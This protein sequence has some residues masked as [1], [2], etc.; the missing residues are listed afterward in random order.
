MFSIETCCCDHCDQTVKKF[1]VFLTSNYLKIFLIKFLEKI[2]LIFI[3]LTLIIIIQLIINN[4]TM[5][6]VKVI[7]NYFINGNHFNT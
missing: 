6:M 4:V 3:F 7:I 5:N 2:F 1:F